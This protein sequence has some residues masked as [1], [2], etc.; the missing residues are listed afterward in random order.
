MSS[1]LHANVRAV[2][3]VLPCVDLNATVSFFT[4]RLG[5]RIDAIHPAEDPAVAVLSGHGAILRLERGTASS[6][7]VLRLL[8]RD[9]EAI[10]NGACELVAPN[11]TRIRLVP[12][13]PPLVLPPLVPSFVISR[14]HGDAGW[15]EGRAGMVYRD[16]IPDRQGGRFVASHIRV[17]AGPVPDY[18]H[19]HR[20]AFQMIYCVKGWVRVIYE[21]QGP[22]FVLAEGDCALQPPGI[23]HRVLESSP[24]LEVVEV[25]SPAEH[26][27]FADHDLSLPTPT[28]NRDHEFQGQRFVRHIAAEAV[29]QPSRVDGFDARDLGIAA[30]TRG[31]AGARVLRTRAPCSSGVRV[32]DGDLMLLFILHGDATLRC[33]GHS[34][35]LR[36]GDAAVVPRGLPHGLYD[37][38]SDLE[39]LEVTLPAHV[40]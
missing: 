10:A 40:D 34:E 27:T 13:D 11:G 30:G 16:L 36:H 25:S 8:C 32:H 39:M 38:A 17:P 4:E 28:V 26:E 20:V 9:P 18:V 23:R 29:F 19:F 37:C 5:F 33:E 31:V 22:P 2:E 35:R 12:A 7:G 6:H 1:P 21:D 3:T 24:G 15:I 14:M